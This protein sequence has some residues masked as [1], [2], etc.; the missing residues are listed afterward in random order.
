MR[1]LRPEQ[2]ARHLQRQPLAPV[3]LLAGMEPLLVLE[4]A[5]QVRAQ[6]RAN[7]FAER[8]VLHAKA[9][10]DWNRLRTTGASL[11]LF[12]TRRIIELHLP[13]NGPGTSGSR[14]LLEYIQQPDDNALLLVLAPQVAAKVRKNAW[15]KKLAAAGTALFAWPIERQKLPGWIR[16]RAA[17]RDLRLTPEACTLL[18]DFTEGNLLACAQEIDRLALLH[19]DAPVDTDAVIAAAADHARFDI[20]DLPTKA[21]A[22]D[23]TGALRALERLRDEGV[24][25]VPILWAL[26]RETRLLYRVALAQRSGAGDS[27][28]GKIFMPAQRKRQIAQAARQA[29]PQTLAELLR[30]AARAD[31]IFKGAQPGRG[32]D[33]LIT[34]ALGLA[35]LAPRRPLINPDHEY[36]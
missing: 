3:Y 8:E 24:S 22:G 4:A 13:D 36:S 30:R 16:Q 15:Y 21:L 6:A 35:G 11:S 20:F 23:T 29:D 9:G 33:E 31:R 14:A 12:A 34:L 5:Q 10:F 17:A 27:V 19:G 32:W 25:E 18:A 28:L 7:G 1:E 26:V 2:L